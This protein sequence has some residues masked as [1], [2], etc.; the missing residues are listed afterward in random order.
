MKKCIQSGNPNYEKVHFSWYLTNWCNYSCNYC[1][2]KEMMVDEWQKSD[3]ISKYKIVLAKLSNIDTDF[4]VDLFGGEPTLHPNIDE[5]IIK[6]KEIP[7]CKSIMIVTNLSRSV[8]FYK[9]F[10]SVEFANISIAGSCHPEYFN[11]AFVEKVLMLGNLKHIKFSVTVILSDNP[12]Y[13]KRT[14]EFINLL[15]LHNIQFSPQYL[16]ST[17][18]WTSNYTEKFYQTFNS[19]LNQWTIDNTPK[20]ANLDLQH[21]YTFDDGTV[22][23]LNEFEIYER[24]LHKFTGYN[25]TALMYQISTDGEITNLC[26]G[27]TI[28]KIVI[29]KL[30]LVKKEVCPQECC[31]CETMFNF[32]KELK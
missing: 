27:R 17:P 20:F 19:I 10:D 7:R 2:T 9:K 3:S 4:E 13:W 32:Y 30:D 15:K 18:G 1:S 6:L 25:C 8:N 31:N 24:D 29:K 26:T 28:N 14:I 5:I 21:S 16:I 12:I 22:E 11:D 23:Q